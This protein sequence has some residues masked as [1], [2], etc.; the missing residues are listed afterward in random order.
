C[1]FNRLGEPGYYGRL[2]DCW[3]R[4]KCWLSHP[5]SFFQRFSVRTWIWQAT[6]LHRGQLSWKHSVFC[7]QALSAYREKGRPGE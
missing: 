2:G 4:E 6:N 3:E 1:S 5:F 7:S